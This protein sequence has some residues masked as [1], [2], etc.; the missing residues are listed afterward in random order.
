MSLGDKALNAAFQST[1]LR[2][3]A[4]P[5]CPSSICSNAGL[6]L[7]VL[8]MFI[9]ASPASTGGGIKTTTA[10]VLFAQLRA[11]VKGKNDLNFAGRPAARTG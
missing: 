11:V 6:L 7:C 4:S 2:T 9:G 3:A 5:P 8:L 1:T 10:F